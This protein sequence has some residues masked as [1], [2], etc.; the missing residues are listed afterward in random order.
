MANW[1][2]ANFI[3]SGE[4]LSGSTRANVFYVTHVNKTYFVV[5]DIPCESLVDLVDI[6]NFAINSAKNHSIP[7]DNDVVWCTLTFNSNQTPSFTQSQNL[8]EFKVNYDPKNL[9]TVQK[10]DWSSSAL[11][12][13]IAQQIIA[14][15]MRSGVRF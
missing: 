4:K 11:S 1:I 9:L 7:F 14:F 3:S 12:Q 10:V 6:F 5:T 2:N 15:L 13:N 8:P